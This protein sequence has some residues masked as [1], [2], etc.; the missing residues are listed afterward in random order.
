MSVRQCEAPEEA[1]DGGN[2]PADANKLATTPTGSLVNSYKGYEGLKNSPD[3]KG[4]E[5]SE[6]G[7]YNYVNQYLE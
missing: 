2:G 3:S 5:G 1:E 7:E 4:S 6:S